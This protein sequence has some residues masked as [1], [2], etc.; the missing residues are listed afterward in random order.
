M[1]RSP[2]DLAVLIVLGC[3]VAGVYHLGVM[4]EWWPSVQETYR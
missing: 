1:F 4:L 2:R 3:L